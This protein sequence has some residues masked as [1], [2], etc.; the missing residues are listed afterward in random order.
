MNYW[1]EFFNPMDQRGSPDQ[2]FFVAAAALHSMTQGIRPDPSGRTY[3]EYPTDHPARLH[4]AV[5]VRD[6]LVYWMMQERGQHLWPP[7]RA[8]PNMGPAAP[9]SG[10]ILRYRLFHPGADCLLPLVARLLGWPVALLM[11]TY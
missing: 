1:E 11:Q 7:G 3:M 2:S 10:E 4:T 8:H 9:L 5:G 6:R